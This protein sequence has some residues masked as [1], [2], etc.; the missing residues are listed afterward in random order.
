MGRFYRNVVQKLIG[1]NRNAKYVRAN[2]IRGV[3]Y[4]KQLLCI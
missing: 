4:K 2:R 3:N 1:E